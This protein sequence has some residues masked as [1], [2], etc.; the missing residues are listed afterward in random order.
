MVKLG[1][2]GIDGLTWRWCCHMF[3]RM[4]IQMSMNIFIHKP[5][6]TCMLLSILGGGVPEILK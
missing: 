1:L 3:I 2:V 4:S 6:S 5:T